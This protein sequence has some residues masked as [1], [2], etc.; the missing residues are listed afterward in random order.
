MKVAKSDIVIFS[1]ANIMYRIDTIR[2]LVQNFADVSVGCARERRDDMRA[3][4]HG[5]DA[6]IIARAQD[7]QRHRRALIGESDLRLSADLR[8]HR[9][10]AVEHDEQ[11]D[12]RQLLAVVVLHADG[13]HLLDGRA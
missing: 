11:R 2:R 8:A 7:I 5:E 3:R 9:T 10:R 4:I 13:E 1:D 6:E 12:G